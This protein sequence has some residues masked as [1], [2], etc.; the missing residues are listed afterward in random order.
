MSRTAS[1]V[2]VATAALVCQVSAQT[3]ADWQD[4]IRNLRHPNPEM[5]LKALGRLGAA[6]YVAAADAVAPLVADPD[7]RVQLAAIDTELTFF[8]VERVSAGGSKSRAQQAFEAGP[9]I[10]SVAPAPVVVLDRLIGAMRDENARVRFDAI[11]ALGVIGESPLPAAEAKALT[12]ELDHYDPTMRAATARV[13]GRLRTREAADQLAVAL[14]DSNA[15]V[16]LF[17]TEALGLIRDTRSAGT[18]RDQL[19]QSRGDLLNATLLALARIGSH[20][21]IGLFRQRLT[22]RSAF[23]RRAAAEGLGRADDKDAVPLLESL[24]KTDKSDEV[25]LAAA[26]GLQKL[27]QVQSHVIAWMLP[28][29]QQGVQAQEYLL[30]LGPS[31]VPGIQSALKTATDVRHRAGLVQMIG[32]VGTADDIASIEPLL[33]D[34]DER[35]RR[36]ATQAIARLHRGSP[37]A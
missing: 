11:H 34:R 30:E 10:R 8:L 17:A 33:K 12:A 14:V 15:V 22:D 36:A 32:A 20:D 18:L 37:A 25:R 7:D 4:V 13:L 6:G 35:V 3:P 21:D 27:G 28:L 19:A 24:L 26:F 23:V 2:L 16:R 29:P 5:R 31:A 1:I 9:L